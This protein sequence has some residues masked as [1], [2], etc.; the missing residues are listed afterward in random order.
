MLSEVHLECARPAAAYSQQAVATTA[1]CSDD[2]REVVSIRHALATPLS[3]VGLQV[4]RGA[5]LLADYILSLADDHP[6]AG[7]AAGAP[8]TAEQAQLQCKQ[9]ADGGAAVPPGPLHGITALELGAGSGLAGLVLAATAR[10]VF[11]TGEASHEQHTSAGASLLHARW[12]ASTSVMHAQTRACPCAGSVRAMGMGIFAPHATLQTLERRCCPTASRTPSATCS[13]IPPS[14]CRCR[15]LHIRAA[16][17]APAAACLAMLV[18]P[19]PEWQC[20]SSTGLTRPTG[21]C[22]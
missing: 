22:R 13:A 3:S 7:G 4:W 5:L 8:G 21:C 11:L 20:A 18:L 6:G 16:A 12:P 1:F 14:H 19:A 15:S 9:H 10:R 17:L 2:G